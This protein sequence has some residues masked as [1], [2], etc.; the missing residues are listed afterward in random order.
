MLAMN[1]FV[2]SKGSSFFVAILGPPQK[3]ES[4]FATSGLNAINCA[5]ELND[6]YAVPGEGHPNERAHSVWAERIATFLENQPSS[7]QLP[8]RRNN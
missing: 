8:R 6:K 4:F 7:R 3:Y 5:L 2:K 1:N